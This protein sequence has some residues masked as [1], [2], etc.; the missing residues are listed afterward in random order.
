MKKQ[1]T[2]PGKIKRTIKFLVISFFLFSASINAQILQDTTALRLIRQDVDYIY[3]LQFNN[4]HELN[5]RIIELYPEHPIVFLLK[6]LLTYWENYPLLYPDPEHLSFV[7]DLRKCI[8]L[9]EN[10][11]NPEYEAEYLLANL[12]ARGTLL[13][14]YADNDVTMEVIPLTI[15]TYKYL[16]LSFDFTSKSIDLYYFTGLYN[17]YR[18]AYP[19]A[20][21]LYKSLALLFPSGDTEAGLKELQTTATNSFVLR[22]EAYFI[23]TWIYLYYEN[24]FPGALFYCKTLHENYPENEQYL[25]LYIEILLHM[26]LYDEA[27]KLITDSLRE[28]VNS[29]SKAQLIIFKGILYEKKYLDYSLAQDCYNKGI[30]DI[31][32]FGGY[33]N[34]Y[35]A[36]AYYGLSRISEANGEKKSSKTYRREA[37]KLGDFKKINFDD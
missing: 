21:P 36:F 2:L 24:N 34:E 17:Y 7:E 37:M 26:K 22:A 13:M 35:A 3:N 6:G 31:S 25:S 29:F 20:H 23:L 12:C 14:F 15:S 28:G 32:Y 27:E 9:S 30:H 1:I 33:G 11:N 18:E 4:A 19:K 10:N 16:R 5:K 8:D